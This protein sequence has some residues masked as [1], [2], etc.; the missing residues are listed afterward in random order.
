MDGLATQLSWTWPC[1][2]TYFPKNA[3]CHVSRSIVYLDRLTLDPRLGR[4]SFHSS[5]SRRRCGGM[6]CVPWDVLAS[7]SDR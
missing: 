7:W 2:G 3:T 5:Y 4:M 1:T 6:D